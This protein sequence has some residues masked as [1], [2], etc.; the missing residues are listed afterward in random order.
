MN[1]IDRIARMID[2][3]GAYSECYDGT[4]ASA[5]KQPFSTRQ[6]YFQARYE[7]L[8][9]QIVDLFLGC[10]RDD[11]RKDRITWEIDG[12]EKHGLPRERAERMLKE[13]FGIPK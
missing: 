2:S 3:E 8:A 12:W 5:I 1:I 6:K 11:I 4:G 10:E 7:Y 13:K 9:I